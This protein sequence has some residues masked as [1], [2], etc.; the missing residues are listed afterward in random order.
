MVPSKQTTQ[1]E[2][3]HKTQTKSTYMP[4]YVNILYLYSFSPKKRIS[5]FWL[6]YPLL[7]PICWCKT[8]IQFFLFRNIFSSLEFYNT[9]VNPSTHKHTHLLR[10]YFVLKTWVLT[11]NNNATQNS[12]SIKKQH[13]LFGVNS[14][15][16]YLLSMQYITSALSNRLQLDIVWSIPDSN[17]RDLRGL[18][19][20]I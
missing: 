16:C 9:Y 5:A 2:Y 4:V 20:Y 10:Y 8:E 7:G 6:T 3:R 1:R 11:E 12:S 19:N 15:R 17:P 13:P 18:L 14:Q